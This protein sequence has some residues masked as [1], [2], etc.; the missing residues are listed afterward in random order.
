M[1]NLSHGIVFV[2]IFE[3]ISPTTGISF[4]IKCQGK[5]S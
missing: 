5:V 4:G 3:L 2:P 1:P